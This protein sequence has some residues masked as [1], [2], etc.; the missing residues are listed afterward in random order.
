MEVVDNSK[1]LERNQKNAVIDRSQYLYR[2]VKKYMEFNDFSSYG[3]H[4]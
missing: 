3:R 4:M 1:F 2:K